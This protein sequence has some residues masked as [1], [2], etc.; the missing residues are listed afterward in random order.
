MKQIM[1]DLGNVSYKELKEVVMDREDRVEKHFI[2]EPI[3]GL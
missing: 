2:N 3:D 1:L